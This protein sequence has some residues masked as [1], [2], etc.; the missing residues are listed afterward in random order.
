[1][2]VG[3]LLLVRGIRQPAAEI[4]NLFFHFGIASIKLISKFRGNKRKTWIQINLLLEIR[5]ND[6]STLQSIPSLRQREHAAAGIWTI[7]HRSC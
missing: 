1:M 7:S 4:S 3:H 5:L 2:G 6:C